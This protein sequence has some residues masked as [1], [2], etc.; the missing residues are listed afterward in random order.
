MN[1][2]HLQLSSCCTSTDL[3]SECI[4]NHTETQKFL[5]HKIDKKKSQSHFKIK[6]PFLIVITQPNSCNCSQGYWEV[7]T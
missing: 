3:G 2:L 4:N 5:K 6:I 1:R 7:S